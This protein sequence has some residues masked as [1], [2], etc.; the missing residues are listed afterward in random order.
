MNKLR[1]YAAQQ[2]STMARSGPAAH[3]CSSP[4]A[5]WCFR[6]AVATIAKA[7]AAIASAHTRLQ[8]DAVDGVASVE[9]AR[10]AM[11]PPEPEVFTTLCAIWSVG[12]RLGFIFRR[13]SQPVC[14]GAKAT[15]NHSKSATML[16]YAELT[17][18]YIHIEAGH[19]CNR[20]RLPQ[21]PI[22]PL[23]LLV[24]QCVRWH[25]F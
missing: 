11:G 6:Q 15:L 13:G 20:P 8:V 25:I 24:K 19:H 5:A 10:S 3:P 12:K 23:T 16:N 17:L 1:T 18:A 22:T 4:A 9:T 21:I 7:W 14:F 2:A